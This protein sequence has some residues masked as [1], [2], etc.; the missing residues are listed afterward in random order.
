MTEAISLVEARIYIDNSSRGSYFKCFDNSFGE[1]TDIYDDT[2]EVMI[3]RRAWCYVANC[4]KTSSFSSV[5][6]RAGINTKF[7]HPNFQ[8]LAT[9]EEFREF[10]TKGDK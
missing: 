7:S 6:N 3:Y 9:K 8:C 4:M 10:I 2:V 5:M 1:I